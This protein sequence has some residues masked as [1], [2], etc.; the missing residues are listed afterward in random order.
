MERDRDMYCTNCGARVGDVNFCQRCG[1]EMKRDRASGTQA[2]EPSPRREWSADDE[3]RARKPSSVPGAG[4]GG[5]GG[6]RRKAEEYV[7][8]PQR[9]QELFT[10]ALNKTSARRGD[11]KLL[12]EVWEYLQVAGRLVQASIRGEY[13]GLSGRNLTLIVGA[14]LYYIS[15]I[16][17]IPDFLPIAGLL[18]DVTVLAF[19]LRS[20]KGELETFKEWERERGKE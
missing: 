5:L 17:I 1:V 11:S 7:R 9:A 15:P 16:D 19:A 13:T 20:L 4:W 2:E 10:T 8:D 12:D 14:I 6:A 18:D 3:P